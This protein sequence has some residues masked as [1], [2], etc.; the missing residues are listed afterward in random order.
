MSFRQ[1][2]SSVIIV[3]LGGAAQRFGETGRPGAWIG[4]TS[5][6][7]VDL[8]IAFWR[9]VTACRIATGR[10]AAGRAWRLVVSES[11]RRLGGQECEWPVGDA[12]R[13]TTPG[14]ASRRR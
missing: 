3:P 6:R 14:D 7:R 9:S 12:V 11:L 2:I 10:E 13:G 1:G 8:T 5:L 4:A